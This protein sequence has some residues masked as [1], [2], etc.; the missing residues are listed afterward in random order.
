MLKERLLYVV[1][2][3]VAN[4]RSWLICK[5]Q[6]LCCG[7]SWRC[8]TTLYSGYICS[9]EFSYLTEE[10]QVPATVT[11]TVTFWQLFLVTSETC[12]RIHLRVHDQHSF[13]KKIPVQD[14][15]N[16]LYLQR[17]SQCS[18]QK[19]FAM[20]DYKLMGKW[21]LQLLLLDSEF[22]SFFVPSNEP[23]QNP[24]VSA[25]NGPSNWVIQSLSHS[26]PNEIWWSKHVKA[27]QQSNIDTKNEAMFKG[28]YLF[29]C[30][31]GV[32]PSVNE[33]TQH[34]LMEKNNYVTLP[35]YL[36][37]SNSF[38]IYTPQFLTVRTWRQTPKKSQPIL[39]SQVPN[40]W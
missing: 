29:H 3:R 33:C 30:F 19:T 32:Y 26:T 38:E 23:E 18:N 11:T 20:N 39:L 16:F 37:G 13:K 15:F 10:L 12:C 35:G 28:N 25:W 22:L 4:L 5:L 1:G 21:F 7:G 6:W 31:A 40:W 27:P 36:G 14:E 2:C 24:S 8:K 17:I 9:S 34:L